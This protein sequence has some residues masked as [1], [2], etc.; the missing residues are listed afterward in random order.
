MK[1]TVKTK[2]LA[3]GINTVIKAIPSR[4]TMQILECV[5]VKA[6]SDSLELTGNDMNLGIR[7]IINADVE[8]MGTV[9]I[10]AKMLND[11]ISKVPADT[12]NIAVNE[13]DYSVS[14]KSGRAKFNIGGIDPSS[15][16][17]MPEVNVSKFIEIEQSQLRTLV[18]GTI[19]A[20]ATD[21][22]K[23]M[24]G[25]LFWLKDGEL[26]TVALDG[27]RVA[28]RKIKVDSDDE[29]KVVVPGKAIQDISKLLAKDDGR[30]IKIGTTRNHIVFKFDDTY[31]T[32][33]LI[34]GEYFDINRMMTED[35][36]SLVTVDKSEI[37]DVLGRSFLFTREANKKPVIMDIHGDS[38][39][40]SI[41]ST[42]GKMNDEIS[43][44]VEGEEVMIGFN[45]YFLMDAIKTIESDYV[46]MYI[47]SAKS[48]CFIRDEES[49]Y[50][51]VVL[52]VFF[53]K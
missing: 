2:E 25:E 50:C 5:L 13:S 3:S 38:I 52:P 24:S 45:P 42:M 44:E 40:I 30:K 9:A 23:M 6:E 41:E 53:A 10:E 4:G 46:R 37:M 34:D 22:N 49:N 7:T 19:F 18:Q 28:I 16:T 32:S 21:G 20:A 29:W 27:H 31:I 1:F 26:K 48:P 43:A 33:L 36:N 11:I 14:I 15:F 39:G 51:Y 17:D 47:L 8:E 35:Y 12:I